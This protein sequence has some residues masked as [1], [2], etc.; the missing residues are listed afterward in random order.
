MFGQLDIRS[1]KYCICREELSRT[2][3][4]NKHNLINSDIHHSLLTFET[5]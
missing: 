4:E 5:D 3:P 2:G 1:S